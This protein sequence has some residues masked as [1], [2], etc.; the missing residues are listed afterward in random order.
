MRLA[1]HILSQAVIDD[2]KDLVKKLLD[3]NPQLL[4]T[5]PVPSLVVKSQHT[6]QKFYIDNDVLT[7]AVMR[8][9]I[10]MIELLLSYYDKLRENNIVKKARI[11]ALSAWSCY[12]IQK[13]PYGKDVIVIPQE[14]ASYAQSLIDVFIKEIFSDQKLSK[15]TEAALALLFN[16]LLPKNAM[17]L[18]GYL[19]MEL[20]LLA[21]YRGYLDNFDAFHYDWKQMDAFCIRVIGLIQSVLA[22]EIAQILCEG[23]INI[24]TAMQKGEEKELSKEAATY[25]LKDGQSFYSSTRKASR[26]FGFEFF[27]GINGNFSSY[28]RRRNTFRISHHVLEKIMLNKNKKFLEYRATI[29]SATETAS[30]CFAVNFRS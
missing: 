26:G 9:Q 4:L 15:A 30:G 8:K 29:T 16:R 18:D 23:F 7:I 28:S 11:R 21:I 20:L 17:K 13:S 19:D 22:P 25:H 6:G 3:K 12:E 5:Q 24:L 27:C 14:Y 10:T 2:D 1:S